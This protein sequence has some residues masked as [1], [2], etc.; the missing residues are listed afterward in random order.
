VDEISALHIKVYT[1]TYRKVF[2]IEMVLYK[3][4]KLCY[5]ILKMKVKNF[6]KSQCSDT[7]THTHTHTH[8]VLCSRNM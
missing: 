1:T 4:E 8:R 3:I 7:H 5:I 6:D 2:I